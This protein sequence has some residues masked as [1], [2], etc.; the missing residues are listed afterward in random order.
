MQPSRIGNPFAGRKEQEHLSP[1][2]ALH[3]LI[4]AL[5]A[6]REALRV[7]TAPYEYSQPYTIGGPQ[8]TGGNLNYSLA[9]PFGNWSEYSVV[10]VSFVGTGPFAAAL[11]A[12]GPGPIPTSTSSMVDR[13]G[14]DYIPYASNAAINL[15]QTDTWYP[16]PGGQLLYWVMGTGGSGFVTVQFRRRVN[17][18]GIYSESNS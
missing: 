12:A 3:K 16:L 8:I 6:H 4:D 1:D 5:H 10:Q 7:W 11:S 15:P 13:A 2:H 14:R 9:S 18:A 17:P